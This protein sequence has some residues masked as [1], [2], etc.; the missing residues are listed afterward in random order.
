MLTIRVSKLSDIE[1]CL[2][3]LKDSLLA[4]NYFQDTGKIENGIM[5]AIEQDEI[6]VASNE[7]EII[8]V[9]R[10]DYKG[11]FGEFPILRL[12]SVKSTHR[13]KR[14]GS[15]MLEYFE[16]TG[17]SKG[18]RIFLCVSDFNKRAKLLYFKK[19]FMEIGK[20]QN[21]Y[22]EGITEFIMMKEKKK[23]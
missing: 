21:L 18:S 3:C 2:E 8:G 4:D 1:G 14:I 16:K 22:K 13:S 17:F 9:M 10:I 23:E 20:I 11:M 6:Y 15:L 7:K 12:I 19:G 5:D